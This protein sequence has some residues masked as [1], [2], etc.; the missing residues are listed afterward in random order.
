[1]P[2]QFPSI[3]PSSVLTIGLFY[4]LQ[5]RY[6]ALLEGGEGSPSNSPG[7]MDDKDI[8]DMWL[9]DLTS[10]AANKT[11]LPIWINVTRIAFRTGTMLSH[12]LFCFPLICQVM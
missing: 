7:A 3:L 4:F 6:Y 8:G 5:N 2:Y 9:L 1:M 11:S 10:L 12:R